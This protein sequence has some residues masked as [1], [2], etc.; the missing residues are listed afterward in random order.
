MCGG[1]YFLDSSNSVY[2]R[3]V[4]RGHQPQ[5]NSSDQSGQAGSLVA[6]QVFEGRAPATSMCERIMKPIKTAFNGLSY[7][8]KACFKKSAR[9]YVSNTYMYKLTP[10]GIPY[11]YVPRYPTTAGVPPTDFIRKRLSD[12]ERAE[13]DGMLNMYGIDLPKSPP[14][15]PLV[16]HGLPITAAERDSIKATGF[17]H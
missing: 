7:I 11:V 1:T 2:T 5:S 10:E 9:F 8:F 13:R 12:S 3:P 16:L 4:A 6:P 17:I 15:T 14:A